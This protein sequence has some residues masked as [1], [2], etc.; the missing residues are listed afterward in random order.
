MSKPVVRWILAT[1]VFFPCVAAA[2]ERG[3]VG[4]FMGYPSLGLIWQVS[5]KVA[6]RPEISFDVSS[7]EIDSVFTDS[8]KGTSWN[9]GFGVAT[10]AHARA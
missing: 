6:L 7:T 10:S 4:V 8:G 3:D 9:I 2:Q 1:L 5:D